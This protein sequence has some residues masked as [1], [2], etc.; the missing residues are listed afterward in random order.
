MEIKVIGQDS[1]FSSHIM[2]FDERQFYEIVKYV[3]DLN[4]DDYDIYED[5]YKSKKN[6]F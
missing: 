3:N 1:S 4:V 5:L 6:M 2:E